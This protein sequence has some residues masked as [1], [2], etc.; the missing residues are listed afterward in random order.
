LNYNHPLL[1]TEYQ[2][3]T[4][5]M[6]YVIENVCFKV[7]MRKTGVVFTGEPRIGK[8]RCCEA[9]IIGIP[10]KFKNIYVFMLVATNRTL[11]PQYS[12][13]VHQLLELEGIKPNSRVT[14]IERQSM[15][16]ERLKLRAGE[17]GANQIVMVVDELQRLSARDFDQ[18]ADIYNRL[19]QHK[20]TLTVVSFAMPTVEGA[21]SDYLQ[22]GSGRHIVGRFF[23]DIKPL[24][25]VTSKKDLYTILNLY[26]TCGSSDSAINFTEEVLP[27]AYRNGFRM[28]SLAD[29]LWD[30]MSKVVSGKYVKNLPMEHV[31]QSVAYIYLI[32][33]HEDRELLSVPADLVE[34]AVKQSNLDQFCRKVSMGDI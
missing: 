15:L 9:L 22:S 10:K 33:S 24:H 14:F 29:Q 17:H 18:L 1:S 8:T 11:N 34:D 32:C 30:S 16:I 2:L 7:L 6:E 27:K 21:I 13:V 23:T 28:S 25:G 19:R 31:T 20:I 5:T 26:D 12:S 3:N 4:P